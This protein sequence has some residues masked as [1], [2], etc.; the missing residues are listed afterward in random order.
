MMP[1]WIS[2]KLIEKKT[3]S[4]FPKRSDS[5]P[6]TDKI[7]HSFTHAYTLG[8]KRSLYHW[9]CPFSPPSDIYGTII[10]YSAHGLNQLSKNDFTQKHCRD[11]CDAYI[12]IT[13]L[14]LEFLATFLMKSIHFFPQSH[15]TS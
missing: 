9:Y 4:L 8:N 13:Q 2:S 15:V 7:V 6:N 3:E 10:T 14:E 1:Y 12:H 5:P 11:N